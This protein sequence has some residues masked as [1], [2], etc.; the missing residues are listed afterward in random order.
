MKSH[1]EKHQWDTSLQI[2]LA[3][4]A[5]LAGILTLLNETALGLQ[6]KGNFQWEYPW[7]ED[8]LLEDIQLGR[9]YVVSFKGEDVGSFGLKGKTHM[10]PWAFEPGS[11]Y[12]Y[13]LALHPRFQGLGFGGKILG[14][15]RKRCPNLYLDC[16]SGNETLKSFYG[17]N[18]FECL[19]DLPEE[20]YFISVF[21]GRNLP[22]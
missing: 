9:I 11:Q 22:S 10:G 8:E 4:T 6:R 1:R 7:P 14:Q 20:D 5:D 15:L 21:R 16:W 18:G 19:G 17:L 3:E 13:Q 12:L 2:R